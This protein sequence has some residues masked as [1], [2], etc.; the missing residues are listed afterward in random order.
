MIQDIAIQ[1]QI[2]KNN[3]NQH[4]IFKL[5]KPRSKDKLGFIKL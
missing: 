3:N 2:I 4:V 1:A 5:Y